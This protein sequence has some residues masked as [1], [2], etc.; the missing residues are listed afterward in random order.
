VQ[1]TH[2]I[3]LRENCNSGMH[4][5]KKK[6]CAFLSSPFSLI[7]LDS[8]YL[9]NRLVVYKA[10]VAAAEHGVCARGRIVANAALA[11]VQLIVDNSHLQKGRVATD[12]Q[13]EEN[14]LCSRQKENEQEHTA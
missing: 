6:S 9:Y 4:K 10:Q 5:T 2:K 7:R 3:K 8:S 11:R 14:G 12:G 13:A 1:S